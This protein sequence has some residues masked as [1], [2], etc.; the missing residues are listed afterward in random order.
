[1]V[2]FK[3]NG[4]V[5]VLPNPNDPRY[6]SLV[7]LKNIL[8][9]ENSPFINFPPAP[10]QTWYEEVEGAI[11]DADGT[12]VL[13]SAKK[14]FEDFPKD[15]VTIQPFLG[16]AHGDLPYD[17]NIQKFILD[18]LGIGLKEEL[19]STELRPF[20]NVSFGDLSSTGSSIIFD[21]VEGFLVDS[22]NRRLGYTSETGA[23]TEIPGSFWLGETDGIG[24]ISDTVEGPFQL[25]L[26]G[27]GEDYYVSVALETENGPAAIEAEGFLAAGEQL[28][29]DIPVNNYPTLDLN[30]NAEGI[31][32]IASLK[33]PQKTAAITNTSLVISD[34]DA[35]NLQSATVT[36]TNPQDGTSEFLNATPTGNITVAYDSATSTLT[37][38]GTDTIANYQQVLS[39]VTYTNNAPIPDLTPREITFVVNDGASFNNLSPTATTTVTLHANLTG[40]SGN[41]TLIGGI[42]NDTLRGV[43]G[44][45]H[46]EGKAGND[47]LDGGSGSDLLIGGDGNDTYVVDNLNDYIYRRTR[48]W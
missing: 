4:P 8:R 9:M 45:D 3:K 35:P 34:S 2:L 11:E 22:Q 19:I 16:V 15:N 28:T 31:D 30:G 5:M 7:P 27:L 6:P 40:T 44:N 1:M 47:Y 32:S 46:L 33:R 29:L 24:F 18:K 20:G 21:P 14:M 39:T 41:D 25:E 12:V 43:G 37:L 10:G 13:E 26:T 36:I 42:G 17:K 23:I 38:S 48:C